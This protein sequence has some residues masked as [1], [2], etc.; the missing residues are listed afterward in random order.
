LD[1]FLII[2]RFTCRWYHLIAFILNLVIPTAIIVALGENFNIVWHGNIFRWVLQLNLV[3]CVNSLAH[4][5]GTKPYDKNMS[6]TDSKLVG[7]LAL[8]EGN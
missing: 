7:F 4:M 1:E 6:P 2:I 8:G 5:W 3:W